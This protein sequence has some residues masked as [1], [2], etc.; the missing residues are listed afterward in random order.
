MSKRLQL[1]KKKDDLIIKINSVPNFV[2]YI[3]IFV[4]VLI[5]GASLYLGYVFLMK[6]E[7]DFIL[8]VLFIL[9]YCAILFLVGKNFIVKAIS[10]EQLVFTPNHFIISETNP[11]Y[12]TQEKY[13]PA[14][15]R[16]MKY[17]GYQQWT[18]HPIGGSNVDFTGLAEREKIVSYVNE[19]GN[20]EFEYNG[21]KIIF[22][23]NLPSWDVEKIF[24]QLRLYYAD[25]IKIEHVVQEEFDYT[26]DNEESFLKY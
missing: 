9:A 24:D 23:K 8:V 21:K 4:G 20:I 6:L 14:S 2:K 3:G 25:K 7:S 17:L 16:E 11:F 12:T 15:I 10:Y 26:Q 5:I 19:R 1:I 22:G 13:E 18:E